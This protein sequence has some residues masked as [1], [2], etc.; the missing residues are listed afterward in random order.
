MSPSASRT[1]DV[2]SWSLIA[3]PGGVRDQGHQRDDEQQGT[4]RGWDDEQQRR[5]AEPRTGLTHPAILT[6]SARQPE[7]HDGREQ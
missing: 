7:R 4:E 3:A 2:E 5:S 1:A 6:H